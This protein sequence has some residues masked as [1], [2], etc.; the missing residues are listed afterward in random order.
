VSV[1]DVLDAVRAYLDVAPGEEMFVLATLAAAVSKTLTNE[2]PIWLFLIGASGGGKT[3]AIRL[4]DP[5]VDQRVD[6]LTR[7]G[8]LSRDK[9]GR[10]VG[11]LT[12]IPRHALVTISDFSTVATMGDHEARARMYGMLR[13]V[14]DGSVYRSIG[15][16]VASDGDELEWDGHLTLIAGAT[17][18]MDAHTSVEAALGERWLTIRLPESSAAR[19]RHRA[20]FVADR[21]EIPQL[22]DQA[23]QFTSD[24]VLE[25]RRR[26]PD[27]LDGEH[28]ERLVDLATFVSHARTGVQFE[29]QGKYRVPVGVP[30]PEEPTRLVGQLQRFAR[31][32]IALGLTA[33]EALELTAT[34]AIDSVPL[35]RMR[36]LRAV[37]DAGE[38]GCSVAD[39]HR[40]LL[41]GNRWAAIHQLDALEAIGVVDVIG[42][43]REDDPKATR[44]YFIAK[45]YRDVCGSVASFSIA[46]DLLGDAADG[47]AHLEAASQAANGD[48]PPW[49]DAD[50]ADWLALHKHATPTLDEDLFG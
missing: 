11:L 44:T 7:A 1:E 26:I 41:R 2:D 27:H 15:G 25:A 47:S 48:L 24:L 4:L 22:R 8:L 34:V 40:A 28:V 6:E 43:N 33:G 17:P 29:G 31:C 12:K 35:A 23:Q 10:R 21:R 39:V 13:V 32:A 5:V 20:R 3:E 45:D 38:Q 46:P 18:A 19:A 42:P 36:T 49:S 16:E 30:T 50:V 37:I 14:Y 9:K